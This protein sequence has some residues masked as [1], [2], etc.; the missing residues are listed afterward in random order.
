MNNKIARSGWQKLL[1]I[2][3]VLNFCVIGGLQA[4]IVTETPQSLY[5]MSESE[6]Y[7]LMVQQNLILNG[8]TLDSV[9]IPTIVKQGIGDERA[10]A[11][12]GQLLAQNDARGPSAL[13]NYLT[14]YPDDLLA[15]HLAASE[16]IEQG[17]YPE[18]ELTLSKVLQAQPNFH[19]A[20]NL[21]GIIRI[22]QQ[23]YDVAAQIFARVLLQDPEPNEMAGRYMT[24]LSLRKGNIEQ[25]EIAMRLTMAKMPVNDQVVAPIHLEYAELLRRQNKHELIVELFSDLDP[26]DMSSPLMVEALARRLEA[27]TQAGMLDESLRYLEQL[28]NHPSLSLMPGLMSQ[29]R[30][31]AQQGDYQQ[32]L[33]LIDQAENMVPV[34]EPTRLVEKAKI[35]AVAGQASAAAENLNLAL[36]DPK[37]ATLSE[38]QRYM[39]LMIAIGQGNQGLQT[40]R[41]NL[42]DTNDKDQLR[43][44]LVDALISAGDLGAA[45]RE[46]V[47]L[48]NQSP[49]LSGAHYRRGILL[50]EQNDNQAAVDAFQAAVDNDRQNIPAWLAL[51][52]AKHDHR[53][54]D[55]AS[56]MAAASHAD[57][58]PLFAQAIE[59]NPDSIV[60]LYEWGLTA[61]SGGQLDLAKRAF[62]LAV[63]KAPFDV[64]S[65]AMAS[66][67]RSD[68]NQR[69]NE[70]QALAQRAKQLAPNNPAVID[71]LG[72]ALVRM[73]QV[74][75]GI[76][77]L[78]QALRAMPGD[79]A[80][81]AHLAEAYVMKEDSNQAIAYI[82]DALKG[83]LPDHTSAALRAHLIALRPMQSLTLDVNYINGL[84]VGDAIGTISITAR[85]S[86]VVVEADVSGL[87]AGLNGMHFHE[88]P[89][90]EAG[91]LNGERIAGM[92][93]GGHYGHDQMMM[94]M[95]SMDMGNMS[96]EEHMMHMQMMKPKGDLPP[97][98]V[99]ESGSATDVVIGPNL[100][101]DE[102]RGRSLIIHQGPDVDG[103]SGPKVACAV[104]P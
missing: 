15:L 9:K 35:L 88:K 66:I 73:K 27:A 3:T 78:Q 90:C 8:Y 18:A 98:P 99:D 29:A 70:A 84:G 10:L 50:F 23:Q 48:L 57:L 80:V 45:N 82:Y 33:E 40:L 95:E 79:E 103:Q 46:L 32:A 63:A 25:A 39:E 91:V 36:G 74:D 47:S 7:E 21:L 89:S 76:Q 11:L 12:V 38:W 81:L 65:L 51:L 68:E 41:Q 16:L 26:S 87:P 94:D 14:R 72:W 60:L 13:A 102:L 75:Q 83:T 24:W 55:H 20:T 19:A 59:A 69:L 54:H 52:G 30:I 56:G 62:D 85:D 100:T 92:G 77:Y 93:A 71:A 42:S 31:K 64:K 22:E 101:I 5:D 61:Y 1:L 2:I 34:L 67:V 43:L 6:L 104:I 58:M 28:Q 37:T 53:V 49:N 44:V 97:L 17:K 4:S 86:G 96:H